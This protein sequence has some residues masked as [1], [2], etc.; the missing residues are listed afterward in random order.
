MSTELKKGDIIIFKAEEDWLSKT[1][2]WLT[3]SD[4]SH[5]AMV[6]SENS[7]IE[8][9]ANGIGIHNMDITAGRGAYI[10]RLQPEMDAAPLIQTADSY[11][12]AEIT[13]DFPALFLL[14]GLMIH[15][16]VAPAQKLL[17]ITNRILSIA[18]LELDK[19]IQKAFLH[20]NDRG[21]VCSQ[22]VYQIF[23]DCGDG[24]RIQINSL[25]KDTAMDNGGVHVCLRDL[26]DMLPENDLASDQIPFDDNRQMHSLD[27]DDN[28]LRELY[29][30]LL[31]SE[32]IPAN[33]CLWANDQNLHRS[34]LYARSFLDKVK[35]LLSL[36]DT[37]LPLDAM[38]I[39]PADIAYHSENL[40][41][42]GTISLT[43][44]HS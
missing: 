4:V 12:H 1:I 41:N 29:M 25:K 28:D 19:Y 44:V 33:D 6:Y 35:E 9:G 7:I 3:D 18:C 27:L 24:Y 11:Y 31:E 37:D 2:A 16:K 36:A 22:L 21:M 23:N 34:A 20:H 13:Y 42:M 5:A 30:A 26:A 38:F 17:S 39:T 43:R 14:A 32:D 10:L 15:K 40:K 8:V